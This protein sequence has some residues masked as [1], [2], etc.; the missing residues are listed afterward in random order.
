MGGFAVDDFDLEACQPVGGEIYP[1]TISTIGSWLIS[2][3]SAAT[4]TGIV[5]KKRKRN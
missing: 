5:Y 3:I 2:G 4:V 1:N